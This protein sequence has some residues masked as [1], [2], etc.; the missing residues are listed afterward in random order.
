MTKKAN[1]LFSVMRVPGAWYPGP[2]TSTLGFRRRSLGRPVNLSRDPWQGNLRCPRLPYTLR[3]LFLFYSTPVGSLIYN[4]IYLSHL[5]LVSNLV[6]LIVANRNIIQVGSHPRA[7][8]KTDCGLQ[9][10]LMQI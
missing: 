8:W 7:S 10:N 3:V 5:L 1:T 2:P 9:S 4:S 6:K